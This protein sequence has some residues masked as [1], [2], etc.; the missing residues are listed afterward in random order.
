[1]NKESEIVVKEQNSRTVLLIGE[2]KFKQL[3]KSHVLVV[4]LGGVGGYAV[5]QLCRAGIGELTIIDSDTISERNINRQIIATH[6]NIGESKVSAFSNRIKDI[7]PD[8]KLH[9]IQEF[10]A[11]PEMIELLNN[12]NYDYV[13]DAIDTLRPKVSFLKICI[14]NNVRVVSSM[15][16]GGKMIPSAVSVA[17]ISKTYNCK[18]AKKVRQFLGRVEVKTGIKA[19]FSNEKTPKSAVVLESSQNKISQ[20]GSISYMPALFGLFCASVVINDIIGA[21]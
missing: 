14:A 13:V 19:V 3:E 5:E 7:N 10:F 11:E 4:G 12:N 21:E 9:S 1:M 8:I 17:D 2:E 18:F 15:G 16:S 6:S 20:V